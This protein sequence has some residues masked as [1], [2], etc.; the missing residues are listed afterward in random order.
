MNDL[1]HQCNSQLRSATIPN[2]SAA[3]AMAVLLPP[4]PGNGKFRM[5]IYSYTQQFM[6]ICVFLSF[7]IYLNGK[8]NICPIFTLFVYVYVAIKPFLIKTFCL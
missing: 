4:L 2:L 8:F 3:L 7:K 5:I 1:K 6:K